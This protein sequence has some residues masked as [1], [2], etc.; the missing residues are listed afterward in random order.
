M[1]KKPFTC[2]FC[3]GIGYATRNDGKR[4]TECR[5]E[6]LREYRKLATTRERRAKAHRKLRQEVI[7]G[8]GGK[9]QCCGETTYEFLAI[10]HVDGGGRKE[11]EMLS[12]AQIVRKVHNL[13]FPKEYRI[14][15]HNC[16]SAIGWF[17]KCPH[18]WERTA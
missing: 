4:C 8:Y 17:G 15:C 7:D 6:Y 16:N 13:N 10:D 14:L 18:A 9:C 3:S 12:T 2:H 11:R 1:I 5:K